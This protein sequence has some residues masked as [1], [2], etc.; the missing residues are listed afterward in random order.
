MRKPVLHPLFS[1]FCLLTLVTSACSPTAP[2]N[3]P[4]SN[5]TSESRGPGSFDL[6]NAGMG[7][8]TLDAYRA[9]LKTSFTGTVSGTE[10][11]WSKIYTLSVSKPR[12]A[13]LLS[14]SDNDSSS[15]TSLNGL[16]TGQ[17]DGLVYTRLDA[18]DP[19][20]AEFL[21]ADNAPGAIE[22]AQLL[23]TVTGA[24][25]VN[26]DET[27]AD[28][29]VTH[30]RFDERAVDMAG[31][32][33]AQGE[34]W[35]ANDGGFVVKYTLQIQSDQGI[36]DP[37]QTGTMTW[38]YELTGMKQPFNIPLPQDCPAGMSDVP[39]PDEAGDGTKVPGYLSYT[40]DR[41]VAESA[42][43]YQTNL[44]SV[45]FQPEGTPLINDNET[46]LEY[47]NGDRNLT[48]LI[49]PGT[50]TSVQLAMEFGSNP[51]VAI[52][53]PTV[54]PTAAASG[55]L[56]RRISNALSLVLGTDTN[57]S[58]FPSYHLEL[59]GTIP[60]LDF[61]SGTIVVNNEQISADVQA[62]NIHLVENK[63][64]PGGSP[65]TTEGYLIDETNY[66]VSGGITQEDI[67]GIQ[68]IWL[69]WPLDVLGPL[70]MAGMGAE[71]QGSEA[72]S[73]RSADKVAIDT[74]KADPASLE[75]AK[76]MMPLNPEISEAH[77]T[78][79]LDHET[80]A[81]LKLVI[82]YIGAFKDSS[83]NMVGSTPG[84]IEIVVSQIG[85]VMVSLPR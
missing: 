28:L 25:V 80:N 5:P 73:G 66:L 11:S 12:Q 70:G 38:D 47:V 55:D 64:P 3:S 34:M 27:L 20:S 84:H 14:I 60:A 35:V 61:S 83:G 41:S 33:T 58:A 17:M 71:A 63:T 45:G 4:N 69:S 26:V 76:G 37:D 31:L 36:Y 32:G 50:Q 43:Y 8:D 10:S 57:P 65:V 85:Q 56:I 68:M 81:M 53:N 72:I 6:S 48:I 2:G 1:I 9:T 59:T 21:T 79:W 52:P 16:T 15:E 51:V 24:E 19:C 30:Y 67:F 82:D 42:E 74:A 75:M 7:V 18:A 29:A 23:P 49:M 13:R 39:L 78:I 22:L 77:G 44:P 54:E 46:H 62:G 40:T